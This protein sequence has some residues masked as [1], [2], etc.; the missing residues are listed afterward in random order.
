MKLMKVLIVIVAAAA[1]VFFGKKYLFQSGGNAHMMGRPNMAK[2]VIISPVA[3]HNFS[4]PVEAV[5]TAHADESID[6]TPKVSGFVKQILFES[7]QSVEKGQLLVQLEDEEELASLK[8]AEVS[9]EENLRELARIKSLQKKKVAT[10]Q[11]LDNQQSATDGAQA[12]LDAAKTR[13]RDCKIIAPFSG[14]LGLRRISPGAL[15]T[16]GTIITTLDKTDVMRIRFTIPETALADVEAGQSVNISSV[17][18]PDSSFEGKVAFID[19]RVDPVT[20]A[21]EAEA[22]VKNS[23]KKIKPGMFLSVTLISHPRDIVAVPEKSIVTYAE[24]QFVYVVGAESKVEKRE[25]SVGE[26]EVGLV[27][28]LSGLAVG[29]NIVV[30]GVM[31][32]KE[33]SSVNP[34]N[35]DATSHKSTK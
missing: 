25:I 23:D 26:R 11:D 5:G 19:S 20:R 18:W 10:Q 4:T 14:V 21:V 8:E 13:Y 33:G 1:V 30:D 3:I 32:I 16:P 22:L 2:P 7:G 24:K 27:E 15:L 35:S 12:R 17:A 34:V 29:E 31:D 9:L 28:I 6:L